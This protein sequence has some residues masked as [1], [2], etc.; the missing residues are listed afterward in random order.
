M[1][2][3]SFLF[4]GLFSLG[5]HG[6]VVAFLVPSFPKAAY[7][8]LKVINVVWDKPKLN[9][10]YK[11]GKTTFQKILSST[12]SNK[13]TRKSKGA[14]KT[15]E[16]AKLASIKAAS[17]LEKKQ[18]ASQAVSELFP[19]KNTGKKAHNNVPSNPSIT[20]H[21][22]KA[23]QPLPKYPWVC[24]KRNQEGVVALRVL[25]DGEGRVKDLTI[26]KSSGYQPL[27]KAAVE[28]VK[29]WVFLE[30]NLQK[31]LSIAFKLKG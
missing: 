24:R 28:A 29:E 8:D 9:Q 2:D 15:K 18:P 19:K 10:V 3:R 25:T 14:T 31:S 30:G 26:Q 4:S 1:I 6:A 12:K 13:E 20:S 7:E 21:A 5:V 11:Q 22:K 23:Y 27:D 17:C 16:R